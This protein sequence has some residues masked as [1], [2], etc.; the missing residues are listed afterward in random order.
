MREK[1]LLS[2][3][4]AKEEA[5]M[6]REASAGITSDEERENEQNGYHNGNHVST[7]STDFFLS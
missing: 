2:W 7:T 3:K 1:S 5:Q 4:E 6:M